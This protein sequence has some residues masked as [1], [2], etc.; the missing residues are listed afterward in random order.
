MREAN[1]NIITIQNSSEK[2]K[3]ISALPSGGSIITKQTNL[4]LNG[5]R[6]GLS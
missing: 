2:Q 4:H 5:D 3:C 6:N 1:M